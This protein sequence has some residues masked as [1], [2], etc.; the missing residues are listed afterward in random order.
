MRRTLIEAGV[1]L[2]QVNWTRMLSD[3]TDSPAWD[4]HNKNAARLKNNLM[5]PMDLAYSALLEDLAARGLLDEDAL[6]GDAGRRV[7]GPGRRKL[8]DAAAAA[9]TGAMSSRSRWPAAAFGAGRLWAQAT[10][11]AAGRR[12]AWCGRRI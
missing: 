7:P 2:V 9:I 6:A 10:R 1:S 11:L 3:T 5:P 4:T 8:N 12:K